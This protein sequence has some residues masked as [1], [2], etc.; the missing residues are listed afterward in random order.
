MT[1]ARVRLTPA[2]RE[3]LWRAAARAA[4]WLG[5]WLDLPWW[6]AFLLTLGVGAATG[7]AWAWWD[8]RS[9]RLNS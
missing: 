5:R 6:A 8:R 7:A 3:A 2:E 9:N 1:G 4:Q